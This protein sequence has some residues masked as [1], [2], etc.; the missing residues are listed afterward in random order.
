MV[1]AS[2][3][4]NKLNSGEETTL[5]EKER[6]AGRMTKQAS[7]PT[8]VSKSNCE[9]K[10]IL[11]EKQHIAG[12]TM[13]K[14]LVPAD[15]N[16]SN[17]GGETILQE[18][19]H[20]VDRMTKKKARVPAHASKSNDGGKTI[21]QEKERI[22]GR[23]KKKALVP[24]CAHKS[25]GG[26][27][28]KRFKRRHMYWLAEF[29]LLI[30]CIGA[31]VGIVV[32]LQK[33]DSPAT[34]PTDFPSASPTFFEGFMVELIQSRSPTTSFVNS[35]SA[36]SR[37]LDCNDLLCRRSLHLDDVYNRKPKYRVRSEH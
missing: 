30:A 27:D 35:I 7:V 16:K 8:D 6:I 23:I 17:S 32:P 19:E 34:L 37:G 26:A 20:I 2:T 33:S 5:Q 31:V 25:N 9:E 3:D 4:A 24:T 10:T 1:F 12:R 13:E 36:Q 28:A 18:K 15:A 22:A 11:Q 21:L 14:A 29:I